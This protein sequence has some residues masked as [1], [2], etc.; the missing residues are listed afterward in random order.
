MAPSKSLTKPVPESL[1]SI[2]V[3]IA[4]NGHGN[5]HLDDLLDQQA[6]LQALQAMRLGDFS[7][8]GGDLCDRGGGPTPEI[9]SRSPVFWNA[10]A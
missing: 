10:A 1:P 4:P 2:P 7:D 5:G 8:L 6:L 9:F 3:A